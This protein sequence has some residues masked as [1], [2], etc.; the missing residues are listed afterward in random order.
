[1]GSK[2]TQTIIWEWV[3]VTENLSAGARRR[4][5]E[6]FLGAMD[7]GEIK[8]EDIADLLRSSLEAN[9][10]GRELGLDAT[11]PAQG[12]QIRELFEKACE[13]RGAGE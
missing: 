10:E 8:S 5:L 7:A 3:E 6:A 1:M 12:E 13:R 2:D 4:R 9:A 11:F